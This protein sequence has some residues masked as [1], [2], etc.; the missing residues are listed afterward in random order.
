MDKA[1][2]AL[3]TIEVDG[4]RMELVKVIADHPDAPP[5][6]LLRLTMV[7]DDLERVAERLNE[8]ATR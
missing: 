3:A 2:M 6:A 1:Q 4:I 8:V 7:A 5:D